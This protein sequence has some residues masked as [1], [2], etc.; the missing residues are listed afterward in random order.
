[1]FTCNSMFKI[2][3]DKRSSKFILVNSPRNYRR[4]K[5]IPFDIA[6]EEK[7]IG[8]KFLPSIIY[9]QFAMNLSLFCWIQMFTLLRKHSSPDYFTWSI[10]FP[11]ILDLTRYDEAN[12]I[13]DFSLD[14]KLKAWCPGYCQYR[15]LLCPVLESTIPVLIIHIIFF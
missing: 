6:I 8:S 14:T 10:S 3:S 1:M 15:P 2:T 4:Q 9:L 5:A 7:I 13:A 12:D 11:F